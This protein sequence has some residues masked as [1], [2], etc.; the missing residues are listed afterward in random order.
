MKPRERKHSDPTPAHA[1]TPQMCREV[2]AVVAAIEQENA[3]LD[4]PDTGS[5][6]AWYRKNKAQRFTEERLR[7]AHERDLACVERLLAFFKKNPDSVL[8]LLEAQLLRCV[9]RLESVS[10]DMTENVPEEILDLFD[11]RDAAYE[12]CEMLHALG[13]T[14][15]DIDVRIDKVDERFRAQ[16]AWLKGLADPFYDHRISEMPKEYWW[17]RLIRS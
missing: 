1:L 11:T 9:R 6:L 8:P 7:D 12:L 4:F 2:D 3:E 10:R 16:E 15:A 14:T 17:W 5:I 13:E